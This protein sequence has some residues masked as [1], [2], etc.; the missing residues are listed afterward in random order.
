MGIGLE[1]GGLGGIKIEGRENAIFFPDWLVC[2][3]RVFYFYFFFG[4][5]RVV[6]NRG[7]LMLGLNL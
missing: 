5:E 2:A 1:R 7:R 6:M 4:R 3:V